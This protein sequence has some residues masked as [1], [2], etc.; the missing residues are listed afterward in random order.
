M[1]GGGRLPYLQSKGASRLGCSLILV[2]SLTLT[3][4]GHLFQGLLLGPG[5]YRCIR[6]MGLGV[7]F[8]LVL[9]RRGVKRWTAVGTRS[10]HMLI[11][12]GIL[13]P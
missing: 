3:G 2:G 8:V 12:G 7:V 1:L 6:T 4:A 10:R 11:A 13:V 5:E 9:P